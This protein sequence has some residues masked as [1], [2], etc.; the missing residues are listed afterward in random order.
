MSLSQELID[1]LNEASIDDIMSGL[2]LDEEM[3]SDDMPIIDL[4]G[5]DLGQK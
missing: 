1:N 4:S 2:E 5:F 3:A